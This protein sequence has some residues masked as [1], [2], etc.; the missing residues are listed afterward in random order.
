MLD[1]RF[2]SPTRSAMAEEHSDAALDPASCARAAKR[3]AG[4]TPRSLWAARASFS[5]VREATRR[6]PWKML[7]KAAA[8]IVALLSSVVDP[9]SL[10]RGEPASEN[11]AK[12]SSSSSPEIETS[13]SR[14]A[15]LCRRSEG[16]QGSQGSQGRAVRRTLSQRPP[17]KRNALGSRPPGGTGSSALR[18]APPWWRLGSS[19]EARMLGESSGRCSWKMRLDWRARCGCSSRQKRVKLMKSPPTWSKAVKSAAL[20]AAGSI[21]RGSGWVPSGLGLLL[22]VPGCP[23][24]PG[25]P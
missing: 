4:L 7:E 3:L 21:T 25:A 10:L 19:E 14:S 2:V 6:I 1:A 9:C 17:P 12:S 20:E 23:E 15:V 16:S 13:R 18:A 5:V 22:G 24:T 11:S 8:L